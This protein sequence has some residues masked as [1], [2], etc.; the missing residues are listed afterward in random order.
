VNN[1]G[2][3]IL[4]ITQST[5]DIQILEYIK[6]TLGFGRVIKQGSTTSRY[7]VEDIGSVILLIAL[8]NGNLVFPLKQANFALFLEASNKRSRAQ[9]VELISSVVIPSFK[10]S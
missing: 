3:P 6:Q 5:P 1:R 9:V 8:F 4:I 10:D 2:T 7:I